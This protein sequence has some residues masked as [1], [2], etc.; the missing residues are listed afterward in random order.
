MKDII[1][2]GFTYTDTKQL[3]KDEEQ[4]ILTDPRDGSLSHSSD[5]AT[6]R[7]LLEIAETQWG[8][9]WKDGLLA[10]V[11]KQGMGHVQKLELGQTQVRARWWCGRAVVNN[12]GASLLGL[13]DAGAAADPEPEE[14][15]KKSHRKGHLKGHLK[16]TPS[17]FAGRTH[18]RR[19]NGRSGAPSDGP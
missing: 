4:P 11:Q 9:C 15:E 5:M 3:P 14:G 6:I 12:A 10:L 17:T 19:L 16:R 1:A 2:R 18:A 8:I 7:T 13:M